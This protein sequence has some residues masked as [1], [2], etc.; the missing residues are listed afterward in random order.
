M[1]IICREDVVRGVMTHCGH[2][3]CK[4]CFELWRGSSKDCPSCRKHIHKSELYEITYNTQDVKVQSELINTRQLGT[5]QSSQGDAIYQQMNP[6]HLQRLRDTITL[7]DG[8][9]SKMDMILR[10]VKHICRNDYSA[11]IIVFSQWTEFLKMIAAALRRESV[12]FAYDEGSIGKS[13]EA[14][15]NDTNITVFL[16]NAR[17]QSSGLNLTMARYL[18]LAEPFI[19][20]AIE[21]QAI[22]RIHRI[23]Q[24]HET[25]IFLF[26]IVGTVEEGVLELSRRKRLAF[27]TAANEEDDF[28]SALEIAE[29]LELQQGGTQKLVDRDGGELVTRD[30]LWEALFFSRVR[31]T[32]EAY[33][34]SQ[35]GLAAAAAEKR[36]DE[37]HL[38]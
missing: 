2:Q 10:Q 1:C 12:T 6:E 8:F 21:M 28:E 22:S 16:L 24:T 20:P 14:F 3:F 9:G 27:T 19:N 5:S 18:I 37:L 31:L 38:T 36:R 30:E 34:E 33:R 35:R 11:K 23:G 7:T 15:K 13:L 26:S 29:S 4:D 25:F 17:S 32:Q